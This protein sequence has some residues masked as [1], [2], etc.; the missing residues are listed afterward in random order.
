LDLL[1]GE[2]PHLLAIDDDRPHQPVI[3]D[4]RHDHRRPCA[5][6][7]G[8][9]AG[10]RFGG[11]I[12]AVRHLLGPHD[13]IVQGPWFRAERS[14][15]PLEFGKGGRRAGSGCQMQELAVVAEQGAEFGVADADR[16]LQH[17]AE[18]RLQLAGR[19]GD[20]TQHLRSRGLLLQGLGEFLFQVGVGCANAVNVSSRLRCL[21]TKTGHA[22]S[23]LH[24]F[25][26]QDH[27]TGTVIVR[28]SSPSILT[29]PHDELA[30]L[31]WIT[32]SALFAERT[33]RMSR[34][35]AYH[36]GLMLAARITLR[37][38]SVS[39]AMSLAKSAG[40]P[41]WMRNPRSSYFALISDRA[42]DALISLVSTST[43]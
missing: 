17:C 14:A 36:S 18:Y 13:A 15:P 21:R 22:C 30:P 12:G 20:H 40:D 38:F 9:H 27:L 2:R 1:F 25:A 29:E 35:F 24:A 32:S 5:A 8:R 11:V 28:V 3:L 37:H 16:F 26:S 10:F 42:R 43:I 6:K 4:H 41:A 19:A 7:L 31:Y 33:L 23:A 39:S 34:A